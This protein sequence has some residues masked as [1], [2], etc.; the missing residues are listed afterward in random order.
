MMKISF[1]MSINGRLDAPFHY[2]PG[3]RPRLAR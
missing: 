3:R 1:S 2:L